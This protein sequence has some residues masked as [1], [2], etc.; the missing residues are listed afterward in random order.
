MIGLGVIWLAVGS[1]GIQSA[2]AQEIGAGFGVRADMDRMLG[3][4]PA[5]YQQAGPHIHVPAR[6]H[7][8]RGLYAHTAVGIGVNGGQDRVEW[9]RLDGY[10]RVYS[11]DHWTLLSSLD[12]TVGPELLAY[13][14]GAWRVLWGVDGGVGVSH[15]WHSFNVEAA[16][17]FDIEANDLEDPMNVDPYSRQVAPMAGTHAN[18]SFWFRP[19]LALELEVGYNLSFLREVPLKK[20][21]PEVGAVRNAMGLNLF[22]LDLSLIWGREHGAEDETLQSQNSG[23]RSH[24]HRDIGQ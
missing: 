13:E 3:R 6:I 7:L 16:D 17:I 21:A 1:S 24:S 5:V 12:W 18:I 23:Y 8:G 14:R 9:S 4:D 2:N 11:D 10:L 22:R 15:S 19:T 20:S